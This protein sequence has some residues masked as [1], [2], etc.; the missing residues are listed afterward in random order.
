M[1]KFKLLLLLM[2]LVSCVAYAQETKQTTVPFSNGTLTFSYYEKGDIKIPH[3]LMEY[4]ADGY[5]EK[6][7]MVDGHREGEWSIV[8]NR[9]NSIQRNI[10]NYKRGLLEGKAI[11]STIRVNPKTKKETID[12]TEEF[13]FQQGHLYGENRIVLTSDTLYCNFD[14]KGNRVG[15]WKLIYGDK[16][17]IGVYDDNTGSIIE[18]YE[19]D[20][21]GNKKESIGAAFDGTASVK[22]IS[23]DSFKIR[24]IPLSLHKP[25]PNLPSLLD[26]KYGHHSS[27]KP[28]PN[29]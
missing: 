19:L 26:I 5:S 7:E 8:A 1:K 15:T 10:Y 13:N 12:E 20:V 16:T 2:M 28:I 4:T 24:E 27:A 25:R 29:E 6:G 18:C 9:G 14:E 17:K 11:F 23:F 21:L 22:L 3:G